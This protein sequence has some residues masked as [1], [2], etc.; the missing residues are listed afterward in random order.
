MSEDRLLDLDTPLMLLGRQAA[1]QL[2]TLRPRPTD[3]SSV[4]SA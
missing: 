1:N 3:L 4:Y 2:D